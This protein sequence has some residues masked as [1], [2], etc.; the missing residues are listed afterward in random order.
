M[1]HQPSPRTET[2]APADAP[3]CVHHWILDAPASSGPVTDPVM[4]RCKRCGAERL[5]S[6]RIE[7]DDRFDD[8]PKT[9]RPAED[10]SAQQI[11]QKTAQ[12]T[13][14]QTGQRTR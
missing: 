12:Q 6:A 8:H 1:G 4:G 2:V 9:T 3:A 13:G 10:P 14:Q 7:P 11:G 5:F